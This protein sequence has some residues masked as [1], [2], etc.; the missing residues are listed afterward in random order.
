[1]NTPRFAEPRTLPGLQSHVH[2]QFAEPCISPV[3]RTTYIP[4]LQNHVHPQFA[5]PSTSPVCRTM[6]IPSLQNHGQVHYHSAKPTDASRRHVL[7]VKPLVSLSIPALVVRVGT[8][9][10][11]SSGLAARLLS[12]ASVQKRAFVYTQ[13]YFLSP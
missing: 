6:Y 9:P 7:V 11:W 12:D 1:M 8:S 5:E 4:S 2:S 3:C 10:D 13:N